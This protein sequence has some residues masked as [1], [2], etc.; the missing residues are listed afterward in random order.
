MSSAEPLAMLCGGGSLPQAVADAAARGGRK[1]VL[2]PFRGAAGG[3]WI[4]RYPHHWC[5]I[6]Q[7]G[8]F[9]RLA[10]ADGCTDVVF[11]GSLI[12]PALWQLRLDWGAIKL[13]PRIVAAFRGGDNHL[14]SNVAKLVEA[15][16]FHLV[17]AHDVAPEILVP[18]GALGRVQPN[19]SDRADI[20]AGF[21]YLRAT[22]PYDVGQAVVVANK[23]IVAVEAAEGTDNMLARVA[24]MRAAG[25]I[26]T[27]LGT[28]VLV[29]GPKRGQD[30]R[31][32]MPSIGPQTVELAAKACLAGIAVVA[33]STI[34]AEPEQVVAAADRRKIFVIGDNTGSSR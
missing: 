32:D 25:R 13:I 3:E 15:E 9:V 21:D 5:Y 30:L 24:E 34:I 6:G 2:F 23:H 28:G 12:R 1:V 8:K 22:G 33:G 29:K 20:A 4:E 19:D 26:R 18:A 7:F 17:G 14:L 16:G 10:K 27:P 11:I 31:F